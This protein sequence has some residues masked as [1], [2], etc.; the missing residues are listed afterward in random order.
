MLKITDTFSS[1]S[2][3]DVAAA[4]RFYSD[5]LG[6][7]VTDGPMGM[8]ELGL[9][10]GGHVTV[11]GKPDHQPASFTVFNLVV[12]NIDEAVGALAAAGVQMQ[13]YDTPEMKTDARGV[14]RDYGPPI[15]WFTDPAGNIIAV[16]E[17]TPG[18]TGS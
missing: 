9:A 10:K 7:P 13:R 6:L 17:V 1:F 4:R 12:P 5:T 18:S 2:V 8:L 16:I 15:A 14:M 3:D 11:Y